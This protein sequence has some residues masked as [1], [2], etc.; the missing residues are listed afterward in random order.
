MT[1]FASPKIVYV[2]VAAKSVLCIDVPQNW[3]RLPRRSS[4]A[5]ALQQQ[6]RS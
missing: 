6:A 5:I 3:G 1:N 4:V 2:K